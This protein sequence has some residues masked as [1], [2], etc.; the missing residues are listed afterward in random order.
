MKLQ[1]PPP[2]AGYEPPFDLE[3]VKAELPRELWPRV[4]TYSVRAWDPERAE[5]TIDFVNHGSSGVAGPWAA[6]RRARRPRSADRPRR[7]LLARPRGRLAP[8]GR[9]RLRA[10][11]DRRV[12]APASRPDAASSSSIAVDGPEEEQPLESPGDLDLLWVHRDAGAEL[13]PDPLVEAVRGLEFPP[14]RV[15]GFVHGEAGAVRDLRRHLLA[16][17]GIPA[18]D[19][20]ISGYWKRR[21]TE[22]GWREDKPEWNRLVE[23]DTVA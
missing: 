4:R 13:D 8:D 12:A 21:R 10:A 2:G 9:R 18:S 3:T 7:R 17:R 6:A 23:A 11:G 1:L 14:G 15:H 16:D 22:E 5:L 19:L 20:S